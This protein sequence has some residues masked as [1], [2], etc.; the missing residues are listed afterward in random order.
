[1]L[2][3]TAVTLNGAAILLELEPVRLNFRSRLLVLLPDS[4]DDP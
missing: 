3:L 4:F 2:L 1:M